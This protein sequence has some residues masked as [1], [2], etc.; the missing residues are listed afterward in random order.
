M[1]T[2]YLI[3]DIDLKLINF[4]KPKKQADYLVCKV[5]YN[6]AGL[7]IQLP[8]MKI[9]NLNKNMELEF[10][11]GNKYNKKSYDFLSNLDTFVADYIFENAEEWF[12]KK[13]PMDSIKNMY[14]KFIKA[15]KS[16]SENCTMNFVLKKDCVFI[17]K[18]LEPLEISDFKIDDTVE[19]ISQLKYI[20]FSKDTCF[21]VW[22]TISLKL[23]KKP[24]ARVPAFGFIQDDS[25]LKSDSESDDDF[26]FCF[27]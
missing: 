22:E 24:I 25:D 23:Y 13:I 26:D 14:N 21:A 11:N 16:S 3:N 15:P 6:G 9:K 8:K 12:G 18:K 4:S 1:T 7:F 27:F 2:N 5:K 19:S 17:D 10:T 20:L